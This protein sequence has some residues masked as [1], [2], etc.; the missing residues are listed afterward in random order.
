MSYSLVVEPFM[1]RLRAKLQGIAIPLRKTC[2]RSCALQWQ[3]SL[4]ISVLNPEVKH[5][6]GFSALRET[7]C[8]AVVHSVRL[9]PLFSVLQR[10]VSFKS[11]L[12]CC[13]VI[14][15]VMGPLPAS[16][17]V[18]ATTKLK[19]MAHDYRKSQRWVLKESVTVNLW[20]FCGR[21]WK[22]SSSI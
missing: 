7:L 3:Y 4:F 22:V 21:G 17:V 2:G 6:F 1:V 9:K 10:S 18:R 5:K 19:G 8:H 16:A 13:T 20:R 11:E 15:Y 12:F 14:P